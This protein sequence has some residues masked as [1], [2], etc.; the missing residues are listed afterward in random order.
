MKMEEN[1]YLVRTEK[2]SFVNVKMVSGGPD[3]NVS[4]QL[5]DR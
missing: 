2:S 1:A 4:I 5:H 3:V